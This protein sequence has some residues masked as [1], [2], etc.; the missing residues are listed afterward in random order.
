MTA[1]TVAMHTLP[2]ACSP[3]S[4]SRNA[5]KSA[6]VVGSQQPSEPGS[7]ISWKRMTTHP[8]VPLAWVTQRRMFVCEW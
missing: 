7:Q 4:Q 3:A 6:G 2:A 8:F 5:R 1:P